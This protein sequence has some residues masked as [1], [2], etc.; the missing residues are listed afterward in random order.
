MP[1]E[2]AYS[3]AAAKALLRAP[4]LVALRIRD[5]LRALARDLRALPPQRARRLVLLPAPCGEAS[6]ATRAL[7]RGMQ[8][9][10]RDGAPN[11]GTGPGQDLDRLD[12][13]RLRSAIS[14]EDFP[15]RRP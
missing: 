12:W 15:Y 11:F 9:L 14:V 8:W 10:Q 2:I 7:A 3:K 4:K 5:K 6:D 1:Y 13:D